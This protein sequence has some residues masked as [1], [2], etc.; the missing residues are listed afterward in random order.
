MAPSSVSSTLPQPP[1]P[2]IGLRNPLASSS[3]SSQVSILFH[4]A[5]TICTPPRL[6]PPPPSN[7]TAHAAGPQ[8][9]FAYITGTTL[10]ISDNGFIYQNSTRIHSQ[11][12]ALAVAR[13]S[14]SIV[15]A[16]AT[17]DGV[18]LTMLSG[19]VFTKLVAM[20]GSRSYPCVAVALGEDGTVAGGS[21]AGQV[22]VWRVEC[23]TAAE[24]IDLPQGLHLGDRITQIAFS[25]GNLLVA[26]WSGHV[27]CYQKGK[28]IWKWGFPV[29]K[30][31]AFCGR[32]GTFFE[33]NEK[34]ALGVF[35]TGDERLGF[36]NLRKGKWIVKKVA[37][38]KGGKVVVKGVC[39]SEHGVFIWAHDALEL[40][41][42]DWPEEIVSNA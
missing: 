33:L 15:A 28:E 36:V 6:R 19:D 24:V 41:G 9:L 1:T 12:Q 2:C 23:G 4:S 26:W 25:Q 8:N 34:K 31:T 16:I 22:A 30:D 7:T 39:V 3:S 21:M 11:P 17:Y 42:L 40:I 10:C 5:H 37:G 20:V 18:F 14:S 27:F 13:T 32:S 35:V 38:E 29:V